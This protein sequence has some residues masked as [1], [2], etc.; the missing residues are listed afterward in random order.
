L[1]LGGG[2]GFFAVPR[3]GAGL[4]VSSYEV[5]QLSTNNYNGVTYITTDR[6]TGAAF[7]VRPA[8]RAGYSWRYVSAGVDASYMYSWGNFGAFGRNAHEYRIGLFVNFNF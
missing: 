7:E 2:R 6:H 8:I 3:I 1:H 5:D 4:L